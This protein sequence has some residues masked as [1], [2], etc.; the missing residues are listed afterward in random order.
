MNQPLH[1]EIL[2]FPCSKHRASFRVKHFQR[3]SETKPM[4]IDTSD[5]FTQVSHNSHNV[6]PKVW[7]KQLLGQHIINAPTEFAW[8][9]LQQTHQAFFHLQFVLLT[10]PF[11]QL[12]ISQMGGCRS[13]LVVLPV[14]PMTYS[15]Q[16][17]IPTIPYQVL[18]D[19]GWKY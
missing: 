5:F 11:S 7:E 15:L 10:A 19:L 12:H 3:H 17:C 8:G 2:Q 16:L 14:L 1:F 13:R 6:L 9:F 4:S 18:G